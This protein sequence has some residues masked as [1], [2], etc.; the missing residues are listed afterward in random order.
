MTGICLIEWGQRF[1]RIYSCMWGMLSTMMQSFQRAFVYTLDAMLKLA[2]APPYPQ[3]L[4][5]KRLPAYVHEICLNF[6]MWAVLMQ[7]S[8]FVRRPFLLL[9]YDI[10]WKVPTR[11]C[12]ES[13]TFH[14]QV[15]Y[16]R[17]Q[18]SCQQITDSSVETHAPA[19]DVPIYI[20][21]PLDLT[22]S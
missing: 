19:F 8:A 10:W 21:K 7:N 3:R 4:A 20:Q 2:P 16:M 22:A 17:H 5:P 11:G 6:S 1:G 12:A 18:L 9:W 15:L 14:D 13:F